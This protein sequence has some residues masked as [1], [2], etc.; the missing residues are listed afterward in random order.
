MLPTYSTDIIPH[1]SI[2]LSILP[3]RT[4]SLKE[5]VTVP[6]AQKTAYNGTQGIHA[7]FQYVSVSSQ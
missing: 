3:F 1:P 6:D 4:Y 2:G 7:I 5:S